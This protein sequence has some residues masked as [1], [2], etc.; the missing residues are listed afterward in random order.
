MET[1]KNQT[2]QQI[3]TTDVCLT[4]VFI[5]RAERILPF[6]QFKNYYKFLEFSGHGL[7]WLSGWLAFIWISNNTNL[8]QMQVNLMIGLMFDILTVAILKA[9][10]RRRRPSK[11][12]NSFQ[13]GPDKYSFPSGHA[14]R[15]S[16]ITYFFLN[17]YPISSILKLLFFAWATLI[18]L[19]RIL[20]RKHHLLDIICGIFLGIIEGLFINTIYLKP[21]IC[22]Y[23]V[24]W[25]TDEKLDGGE[26]HV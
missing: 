4:N 3:L 20:L 10:T 26:F 7:L 5:N 19:S 12:E 11:N 16:F 15:A 21:A 25:I 23:L 24:S 14:S 9:I 2:L 8:H 17:I 13:I 18:C 22:I 1:K 6:W